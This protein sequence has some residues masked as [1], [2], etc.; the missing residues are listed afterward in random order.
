MPVSGELFARPAEK[1]LAP[2]SGPYRRS[3]CHLARDVEPIEDDLLRRR[4]AGRPAWRRCTPPTCPSRRRAAPAAGRP[5]TEHSMRPDIS[6]LRSAATNS[7]V[8]RWTVEHRSRDSDGPCGTPSLRLRCKCSATL[9][10]REWPSAMMRLRTQQASSQLTPAISCAPLTVLHRRIRPMINRIQQ[11]CEA[12]PQLG[13]RHPH[14]LHAMGRTLHPRNLGMQ[15]R[16]K[17]TRV[18]DYATSALPHDRR[19]APSRRSRDRASAS[20]RAPEIRRPA[21]PTG[22]SVIARHVPGGGNPHS[23]LWRTA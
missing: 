1:L 13:P 2:A 10:F 21:R 7:T 5:S 16:L 22:F 23:G 20:A 15:V 6:V 4:L 12:A 3:L 9:A 18:D 14:L 8:A 19:R 17:L 11:H